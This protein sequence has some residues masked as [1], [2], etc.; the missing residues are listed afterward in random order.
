[1]AEGQAAIF[2]RPNLV[3]SDR[4]AT[5]EPASS[6]PLHATRLAILEQHGVQAA[7]LAHSRYWPPAAG[8]PGAGGRASAAN[9]TAEAS[10]AGAKAEAAGAASAR[11]NARAA[12]ERGRQRASERCAE[13]AGLL[14][15]VE[16]ALRSHGVIVRPRDVQ[17]RDLSAD[18][19]HAA[20]QML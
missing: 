3:Y 20:Q 11:A 12:K 10:A 5:S 17:R 9:A 1:V 7:T 14:A 8:G 13:P 6:Q 18:V 2:F 4:H 19:N 16:Q 15:E